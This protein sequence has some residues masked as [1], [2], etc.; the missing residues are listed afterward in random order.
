[1]G[2]RALGQRGLI[3]AARLRHHTEVRQSFRAEM[4]TLAIRQPVGCHPAAVT[5]ANPTA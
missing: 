2:R 1:M 5:I 4:M 3:V